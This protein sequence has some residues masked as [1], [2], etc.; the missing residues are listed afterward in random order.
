MPRFQENASVSTPFL[1]R[2]HVAVG[3]AHRH[4]RGLGRSLGRN[5]GWRRR[6]GAGRPALK[7]R[8]A[9][10][11]DGVIDLRG[12]AVIVL[13]GAVGRNEGTVDSVS[14]MPLAQLQGSVREDRDDGQEELHFDML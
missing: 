11:G 14:R 6:R 3:V 1:S 13:V 9:W 7:G 10:A 8:L 4:G 12:R 5:L 2:L